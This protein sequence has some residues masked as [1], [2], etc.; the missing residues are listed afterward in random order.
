MNNWSEEINKKLDEKLQTAK[1]KDLRFFRIEEFKRMIQ[2][3]N[4][5]SE[6]CSECQQ[7]KKEIETVVETI[8]I[9]VQQPGKVRRK[10]DQLSDRMSKHQRKEHGYFPP[11]YFSYLYSFYGISA[12]IAIGALVGFLIM[13]DKIWHFIVPGFIAGIL[14]SQFIGGR[15]DKKVRA[16]KKLL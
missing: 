1:E 8:D 16:N 12:G 3:N 14:I 2:R 15:K 11:Y 9:A 13:P 7:F 4:E 5:F 10:Y 6:S